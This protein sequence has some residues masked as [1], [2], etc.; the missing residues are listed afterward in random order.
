MLAEDVEINREIT[1]ALLEHT[2]I[3][4]DFAFDGEEAV[5]KFLH[6]PGLYELI[7]MDLH[8]PNMDGYEATQRIRTSGLPGEKII[9]I[10]AM[11]ANVFREDIE[12]CI[13]SGMNDHLGKPID[14]DELIATLRKYLLH[15]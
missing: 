13:A 8:M 14:S 7:L 5:E 9:P 10:I 6:A 4:I 11:T 1:L 12:S 3:E 2:G 15:K